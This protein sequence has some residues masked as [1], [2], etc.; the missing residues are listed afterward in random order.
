[1]T[2]DLFPQ[3]RICITHVF[4]LASV[5]PSGNGTSVAESGDCRWCCE[6]HTRHGNGGICYDITPSK[7]TFWWNLTIITAEYMWLEIHVVCQR[8]CVANIPDELDNELQQNLSK[9]KTG[10]KIKLGESL[11][12]D[13]CFNYLGL[14]F[15]PYFKLKKNV[16]TAPIICLILSVASYIL[17]FYII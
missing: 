13:S 2:Q 6:D 1:M 5:W 7:P 3:L 11:N 4:C 9:V 15:D 17:L 16:W 12:H 10:L 8:T 14:L